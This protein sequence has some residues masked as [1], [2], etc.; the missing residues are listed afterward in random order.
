MGNE[1]TAHIAAAGNLD[2]AWKRNWLVSQDA[3]RRANGPQ[4]A[5]SNAPEVD[6]GSTAKARVNL[7]C[8]SVPVVFN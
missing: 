5:T 8:P 3:H 1:D 4:E 2:A 6:R 7:R